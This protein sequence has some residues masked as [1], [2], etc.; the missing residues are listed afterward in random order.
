MSHRTL[1][2]SGLR[3]GFHLAALALGAASLLCLP[4]SDAR[5]NAPP[6]RYSI[7]NGTVTDTATK[8]VWQQAVDPGTY[9]WAQAKSY[10]AGLSL[11]GGGWR[12]PSV[13]ELMTLVDFS[14]ASPGPTIDT[15]AF[16]NTPAYYFWSSSPLAGQPSYAYI[17]DF[18]IGYTGNH[19]VTYSNRVR[20]VR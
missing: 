20:C 18:S 12:V 6:G 14:V 11:A 15:T 17:V 16:P 19:F 5:A 4:A 8:L 1:R 10:C 13:K 7:A 9:T 3:R 2:P